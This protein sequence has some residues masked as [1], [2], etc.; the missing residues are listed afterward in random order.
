MAILI[1][2]TGT[3]PDRQ[4]ETQLEGRRYV[5]R[6]RWNERAGAWFLD[7]HTVAGSPIVLGVRLSL[8]TQPL[9]GVLHPDRPPGELVVVDR[10]DSGVEAAQAD[11][12]TRVQLFYV[13]ASSLVAS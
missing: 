9:A 2:P 6:M 4:Q 7:M 1:V 11:L 8:S 5:L 3:Y 12:G 13:E 10:T